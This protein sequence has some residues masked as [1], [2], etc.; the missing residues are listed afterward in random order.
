ML[1]LHFAM[2]VL[3]TGRITEVITS[4]RI[5][6]SFRRRFPTY[7]WTCQRCVSVWAGIFVTLMFLYAPFVNWPFAMSWLFLMIGDVM[8]YW[9][10]HTKKGIRIEPLPTGQ[11]NVDWNGHNAVA[12]LPILK[13]IISQIEQVQPIDRGKAS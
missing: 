8:A 13:G 6:D 9:T 7:L 1:I 10:S 11:V 3:A 4:D 2:A 5:T 12:V